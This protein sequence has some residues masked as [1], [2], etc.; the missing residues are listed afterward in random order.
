MTTSPLRDRATAA[1]NGQAPGT[2]VTTTEAPRS[3]GGLIQQLRP[4]LQRALPR[5]LDADRMARMA[6]TTIRQTPKLAACTPQSFAGA[7]LTAAAMGLDIGP[8]GEAYLVPYEI[9]KGPL[10]GGVECQL[11]V[12]YQGMAKLF[13]Q[14]TLAKH[15]D[16]QAVYERDDF[17]YSYGLPQFLRHKP[18]RGERGD[19]IYYY[20]VAE[21]T[22]GG[23][24]FVVL[25][26]D[27]VK[28]LRNNKVGPSGDIPDPM[29]WME[30]KTALRQ[31]L[32]TLPR[33]ATLNMAISVDEGLGSELYRDRID[34]HTATVK[35][36]E[37]PQIESPPADEGEPE[38]SFPEPTGDG[39]KLTKPQLAKI[40]AQFAE[41]NIDNHNSRVQYATDVVGRPVESTSDL[42]KDEASQ[43]IEAQ[44]RD[45]EWTNAPAGPTDQD[46]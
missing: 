26:P 38:G 35:V 21:L 1:A 15:L 16:A 44:V 9:R 30:R 4:E 13:W 42:T 39:P 41:L 29:R 22:T 43:V 17:D 36:P 37:A 28:K 24:A 40:Q 7:I 27:E 19:V 33:S 11:I 34:E 31:L 14:S 45:I 32:K 8:G 23:S 25:T 20:A 12:G 18:A 10:R 3:I 2:D 46:I 5:H 6:L